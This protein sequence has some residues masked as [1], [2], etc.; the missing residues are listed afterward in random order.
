[1]DVGSGWTKV[2]LAGRDR[3]SGVFPT[4][5]GRMDLRVYDRITGQVNLLFSQ[6][7]QHFV[8]SSLTSVGSADRFHLLISLKKRV[9]YPIGGTIV[10]SGFG[11]P[12]SVIRVVL[13][14]ALNKARL[15][16]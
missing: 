14:L 6:S 7:N 12:Y 2:G 4:I 3:P 13:V 1:M 15:P 10:S 8:S 5:V 9:G 16:S 11:P